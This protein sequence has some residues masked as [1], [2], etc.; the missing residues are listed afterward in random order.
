M[1]IILS[2]TISPALQ[3]VVSLCSIRLLR[4]L[5]FIQAK[6][7]VPPVLQSLE[8]P[9]DE[10]IAQKT[11]VKGCAYCGGPG[12][13]VTHCPKLEATK[14]K[15]GGAGPSREILKMGGGEY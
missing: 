14:M 7:R 15:M 1:F 11:G 8:D 6:Q 13:R 12:H 5:S 4:V 3:C 10:A 2:C 9:L